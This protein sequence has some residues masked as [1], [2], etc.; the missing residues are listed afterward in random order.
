MSDLHTSHFARA[1]AAMIRLQEHL[2]ILI[3]IAMTLVV[4]YQIAARLGGFSVRWTEEFAR[5]LSIWATFLAVPIL[6]SF[7]RLINIDYFH[8]RMR[9]RPR[10]LVSYLQI[11]I[12][13]AAFLALIW[14]GIGQVQATWRQ[15]SPGLLW[16]MGLF[17]L[18]IVVCSVL[19]LAV[20][21]DWIALARRHGHD[22]DLD[23][24]L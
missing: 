14:V 8:M 15:T 4:I 7:G 17:T 11:A 10:H 24:Y 20:I 6:I 2:L 3:A 12:S 18:P 22:T 9:R 19:S 21:P 16:P 1:R 23:K 13:V 5:F